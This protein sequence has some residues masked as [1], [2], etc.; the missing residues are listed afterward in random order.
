MKEGKAKNQPLASHLLAWA[1]S[2]HASENGIFGLDAKKRN[3][4]LSI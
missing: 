4:K 3:C 1:A 2:K